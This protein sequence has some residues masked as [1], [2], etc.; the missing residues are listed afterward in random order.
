MSKW[1]GWAG[2]GLLVLLAYPWVVRAVWLY[3][4]YIKWVLSGG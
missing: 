2:L 4:S 3:W 1:A